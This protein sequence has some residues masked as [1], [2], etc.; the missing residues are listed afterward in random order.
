MEKEKLVS[1]LA[2]L[3]TLLIITTSVNLTI[4]WMWAAK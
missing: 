3:I 2:L 1:I 4:L